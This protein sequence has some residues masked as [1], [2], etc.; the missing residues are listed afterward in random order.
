VF[1]GTGQKG[2]TPSVNWEEREKNEAF[3][4]VETIR[5]VLNETGEKPEAGFTTPEKKNKNKGC[6]FPGF[7]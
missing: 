5:G 1:L 6:A 2:E 3:L 7:R 4:W